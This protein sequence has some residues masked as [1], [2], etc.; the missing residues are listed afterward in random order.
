MCSYIVSGS[1][2]DAQGDSRHL[3]Y[4]AYAIFWFENG[5]PDPHFIV[6]V[7]FTGKYFIIYCLRKWLDRKK[8]SN[9]LRTRIGFESEVIN[10]L[11]VESDAQGHFFTIMF[12]KYLA[13]K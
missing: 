8:L 3:L 11:K 9:I 13:W 12:S 4:F 6:I 2:S 1:E 5:A 10:N 7:F